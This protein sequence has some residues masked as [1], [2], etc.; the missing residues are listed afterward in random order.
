MMAKETETKSGQQ[1]SSQDPAEG[2]RDIPK[3]NATKQ[4]NQ[5]EPKHSFDEKS[6]N[7]G[8]VSN[9][10]PAEGRRDVG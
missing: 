10:D 7:K 9:E 4:G 3:G 8:S 6:E 5:T 1:Q 2:R